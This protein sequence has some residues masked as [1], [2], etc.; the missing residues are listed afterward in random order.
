[1]DKGGIVERKPFRPTIRRNDAHDGIV[2]LQWQQGERPF[3]GKALVS[4]M[5]MGMTRRDFGND[6]HL[7]VIKL[8]A[9]LV[10]TALGMDD[11]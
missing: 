1:M 6:G 2:V 9:G 11:E 10:M 3:G 5:V 4:D 7:R 8:P